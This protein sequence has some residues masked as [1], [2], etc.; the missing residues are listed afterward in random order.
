MAKKL[1][2]FMFVHV[3]NEANHV[4]GSRFPEDVFPVGFD[5]PLA[6]AQVSGDLLIAEF[7]LDKAYHFEFAQ[8]KGSALLG[9]L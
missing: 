6:D 4:V 5:S 7:F 3:L 1:H 8:G 2:Q 9:S